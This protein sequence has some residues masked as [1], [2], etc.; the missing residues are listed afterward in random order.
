MVLYD[1]MKECLNAE[2]THTEAG[3]DYAVKV[4]GDTIYLLFEWSDGKEDWKSNFNFP[5]KAYKSGGKTWFAHRG[6]LAAWKDIRDEI[7]MR[8]SE[9]LAIYGF[10]IEK[11]RCIG[12]SHGAALAQLCTE[13]MVYLY[14]DKLDVQGV[15]FGC[16][17]VVWGIVPKAVKTRL[18]AFKVVRN[19][20]D[21]VTHVPPLAFG[22]RHISEVVKIGQRDQVKDHYPDEYL[23]RLEKMK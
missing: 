6:F 8:V 20:R 15:G 13:D 18:K 19:G 11:I 23:F 12:Y 2:Y 14:G 7:E 5:A 16:P 4:S 21:I 22:F 9:I 17:R 1:A 10:H 3:T